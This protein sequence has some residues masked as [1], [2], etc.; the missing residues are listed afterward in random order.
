[1]AGDQP[2]PTA[3]VQNG[4]RDVT[5]EETEEPFLERGWGQLLPELI[6]EKGSPQFCLQRTQYPHLCGGGALERAL[7]S[8]SGDLVIIQFGHNDGV[9]TK[10][11][12]T[13]PVQFR[14]NLVAFV[15]EVKAKGGY[16]ILC[17][18]V[19]RRKFDE[20]GVLMPT[21]G[22]YPDIVRLGS[23]SGEGYPDRHGDSYLTLVK[24]G[25]SGEIETV[26]P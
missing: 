5:G 3:A 8:D 22:E 24:G 23:G 4:E 1:M 6:S 19:A 13:N 20:K 21:H 16:P 15:N 2:W 9:T 14:L 25:R 18:P 11:S 10:A 12:Y 7:T 17:T 26:L